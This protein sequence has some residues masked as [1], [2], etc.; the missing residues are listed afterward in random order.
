LYIK[1]AIGIGRYLWHYK[2][3]V[4]V[5]FTCNIVMQNQGLLSFLYSFTM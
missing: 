3:K 4:E 5:V 2:H 1:L